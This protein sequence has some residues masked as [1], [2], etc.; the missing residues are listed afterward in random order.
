PIF[1]PDACYCISC[2]EKFE[3]KYGLNL[4]RWEDWDDPA[5]RQF[6]DFRYDSIA[7]YLKD[8]EK[9]LKR[10]RPNAIIYMNSTG[11]WP[12]WPAA[13]ENRR[14]MPYQDILAR[15][16]SLEVGLQRE[17]SMKAFSA[18]TRFW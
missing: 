6:I 12:A 9:T 4:P 13:R 10:V 14:L 7:E 3:R 1:A 18:A 11:L 16:E 2:R 8:A 17:T 5:W 15:A